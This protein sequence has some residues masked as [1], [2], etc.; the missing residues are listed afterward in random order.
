[1]R[2]ASTSTRRAF[3]GGLFTNTNG[4][5]S[6]P[7]PTTHNSINTANC[8]KIFLSLAAS[9]S[10][11]LHKRIPKSQSQKATLVLHTL[12]CI[13]QMDPRFVM[14]VDV[15]GK[16]KIFRFLQAPMHAGEAWN[17]EKKIAID[18]G[19]KI[20][21]KEVDPE[22]LRLL[23]M[24]QVSYED[25]AE[26]RTVT[27]HRASYAYDNKDKQHDNDNEAQDHTRPHRVPYEDRNQVHI[28]L[29]AKNAPYN[30]IKVIYSTTGIDDAKSKEALLNDGA[31]VTPQL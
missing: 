4:G 24:D 26:P 20:T 10:L 23:R 3:T 12:E 8:G 9:Y 15:R 16:E 6:R 7:T 17:I 30:T 2:R 25:N 18:E 31:S 11:T 19:A 28:L 29:W 27:T 1:M 21:L 13:K 14:Q 5:V 22:T